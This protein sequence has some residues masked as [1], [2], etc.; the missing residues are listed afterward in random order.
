[1]TLEN[2][3]VGLADATAVEAGVE[4]KIE[5]K[6]A[7]DNA[8]FIAH[9]VCENPDLATNVIRDAEGNVVA[10]GYPKSLERGDPARAAV[11]RDRFMQFMAIANGNLQATSTGPYKLELT[12]G[13]RALATNM[14]YDA[15]GNVVAH[16][17]PKALQYAEPDMARAE[18][19]RLVL[20]VKAVNREIRKS[21]NG[22]RQ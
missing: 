17:H 15:K 21:A 20:L 22:D 3:A 10:R 9:L 19:Q 4:G 8:L 1:M 2:D 12:A 7:S 16:G 11:E 18:Q 13:N 14:V 6:G 5:V